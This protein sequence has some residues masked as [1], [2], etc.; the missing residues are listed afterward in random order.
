[1]SHI[2]FSHN[3]TDKKGS[4]RWG[5]HLNIQFSNVIFTVTGIVYFYNGAHNK[6]LDNG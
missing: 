4:N 5:I 1:M 3:E 2:I 6:V